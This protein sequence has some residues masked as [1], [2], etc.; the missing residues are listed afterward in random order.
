M[1]DKG[2]E[3][4]AAD[5]MVDYDRNSRMQQVSVQSKAALLASLVQRIGPVAPEFVAMDYGCGPGRSAIET[6]RPIVEAYRKLDPEGAIAVRHGDQPGNDWNTLIGLSTGP[7]GYANGAGLV[8]TEAAIGTF[9]KSMAAPGSIALGTCFG[10]SHWLS[11]AQPLHAPNTL[12]FADLE[13]E[14]RQEFEALARADWVQFLRCRAAELRPGG[15]FVAAPLGSVPDASE[16]NGTKAAAR[17]LYRAIFTVADGMARDGVLQRAVL[18]GFV[19][20]L[21]F[22]TVEEA[23]SWLEAEPDLAAAF[24]VV[25]AEVAPIPVHPN[26]VYAGEIGDP[27]RYAKLYTGYTRGFG[28]MTLRH[29][30]FEPSAQTAEQADVLTDEFFRRYETLYCEE[31][32]RH[33]SETLIL[34]LVLR[35]R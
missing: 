11:R 26:D 20:P 1:A 28:E 14:A 33:A 24:E 29:H 16:T 18:D 21:W 15:Y 10:A 8:R 17:K 25:D 13:G 4:P 35:R 31:L 6:V 27:A 30:L 9:Y 5:H 23:T 3:R 2:R 32:G 19:F 7:D 34:T 12:F 22:L